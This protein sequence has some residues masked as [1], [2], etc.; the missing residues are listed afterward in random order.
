[1]RE[2]LRTSTLWR[3][4]EFLKPKRFQYFAAMFVVAAIFASERMFMGFVAKWFIDAIVYADMALLKNTVL[5]WGLYALGIMLVSPFF[6]YTWRTSIVRGTANLRQVV[7]SHLQRLP[8][9]YYENRHSGEAMSLL[10][11]DVAAAEQVYGENIYNLILNVMK[12]LAGSGRK[13]RPG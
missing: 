2:R 6:L 9:G 1:M 4:F 13:H 7:F 10:T 5:Y 12:G 11:N 8:L 3:L